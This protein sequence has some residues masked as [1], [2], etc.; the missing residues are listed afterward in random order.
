MARRPPGDKTRRHRSQAK[1]L[2]RAT[3]QVRQSIANPTV[4]RSNRKDP[5][6]LP[7]RL[8]AI[9]NK[10]NPATQT[11]DN[12]AIPIKA[13]QLPLSQLIHNRD[14]RVTTERQLT[15]ASRPE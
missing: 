3:D 13:S 5:M 15:P 9:R 4:D 10:V 7:V 8:Q 11:R 14:S 2:A 12:Q 1:R 6:V